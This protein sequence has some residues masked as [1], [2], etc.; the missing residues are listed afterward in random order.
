[1][2]KKCLLEA[3]V[4]PAKAQRMKS[5]SYSDMTIEELKNELSNAE[6]QMV[7]ANKQM[8]SDTMWSKWMHERIA[9]INNAIKEKTGTKEVEEHYSDTSWSRNGLEP[10]LQ[11]ALLPIT[12]EKP[13]MMIPGGQASG[14]HSFISEVNENRTIVF[15]KE[16]NPAIKITIKVGRDGR[17]SDIDNLHKIRF[18][19][20]KGQPFNRGLETWA[21]VNGFLMDGKNVGPEKKIFGVKASDYPAGHPVRIMYPNKFR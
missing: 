3:Y 19:Y 5:I 4:T 11:N 8:H 1:M 14:S 9:N 15:Q 2:V 7:T 12:F 13:N 21:S 20:V 10:S 17:I 16:I 6:K 18:P